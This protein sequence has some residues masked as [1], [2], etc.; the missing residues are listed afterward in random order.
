MAKNGPIFKTTNQNFF[1]NTVHD[2]ITFSMVFTNKNGGG[3]LWAPPPLLTKVY[4]LPIITKVKQPILEN[5]WAFKAFCCGCP[6]EK[7][8][9]TP[10]KSTLKYGS[11]NRP[12]MRGFI[13]KT[14][15]QLTSSNLVSEFGQYTFYFRGV[16]YTGCNYFWIRIRIQAFFNVGSDQNTGIRLDQHPKS[17]NL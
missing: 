15:L 14:Q 9:S 1:F 17:Y 4:L 11:K 10:S 8:S 7:Y 5:A 16:S 6:Y 12:F 13:F 3:A 2:L